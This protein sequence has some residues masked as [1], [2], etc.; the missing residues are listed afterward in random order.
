[1]PRAAT[2]RDVPDVLEA[3]YA[4]CDEERTN[5]N[6]R[7]YWFGATNEKG[8]HGVALRDDV[9][10]FRKADRRE[11]VDEYSA[12]LGVDGALAW[13]GRALAFSSTSTPSARS[14]RSSTPLPRLAATTITTGS[15]L[16]RFGASPSMSALAMETYRASAQGPTA[17]YG[18]CWSFP[19]HWST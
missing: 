6:V 9:V 1:M 12:A 14:V 19:V 7:R 13:D 17:Y 2:V 3:V 18:R 16:R 4:D 8:E 10:L 5:G 11:K 15:P